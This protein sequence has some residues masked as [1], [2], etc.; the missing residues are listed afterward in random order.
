MVQISA[1]LLKQWAKGRYKVF[2]SKFVFGVPCSRCQ[3]KE[4]RFTIFNSKKESSRFCTECLP[5]GS[6]NCSTC[7]LNYSGE[8][9]TEKFNGEEICKFCFQDVKTCSECKLDF[10]DNEMTYYKRKMLCES[11][12]EYFKRVQ[13]GQADNMDCKPIITRVLEKSDSLKVFGVELECIVENDYNSNCHALKH[14]DIVNDESL[15][16]GGE[17][18]VSHRVAYNHSGIKIMKNFTKFA[19]EHL[20]I[21]K[22]C[23]FHLHIFIHK[24]YFTLA[25]FQK[26]IRGYMNMED[27]FFRAA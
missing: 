25:N 24:D 3:V 17:E 22:T 1:L 6:Y 5:K 19:K 13:D 8:I 4:A 27:F 18:F 12:Y 10:I 2:R 21:D 26:I 15:S 14:F 23:G 11:C 20:W 9:K 7:H 16:D